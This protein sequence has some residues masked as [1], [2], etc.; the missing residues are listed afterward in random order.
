[1]LGPREQ[2]L[3]N[4]QLRAESLFDNAVERGLIMPSV[5]ESELSNQIHELAVKL[6]G[7]RR[8]WHQRIVRSGPNTLLTYYDEAP[9]RRIEASDVVFFDFG[10]VFE[11][12]EADLGRSYVLG[13]DPRKHRLVKD[14]G[15]AFRLGQERLRVRPDDNSRRSLRLSY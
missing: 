9:D 1:M 2:A 11:G 7:L 10:P 5:L 3:C 6:Y 4:T 13:S 12:W 8:H 15:D 14:L